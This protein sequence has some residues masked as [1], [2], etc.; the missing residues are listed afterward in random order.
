[1]TKSVNTDDWTQR[2]AGLAALD[3]TARLDHG[4]QWRNH[5]RQPDRAAQPGKLRL[6]GN[7]RSYMT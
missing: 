4:K 7:C 6:S 3:Q 1:M 2:F 5:A